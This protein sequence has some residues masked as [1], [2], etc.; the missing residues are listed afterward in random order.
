MAH[1]QL[2]ATSIPL[3]LTVDPW[4]GTL[5]ALAFGRTDDG[6]PRSQVL[7]LNGE[8]RIHL[9]V[10]APS[11]GPIIGFRVSAP[12]AVEVEAVDTETLWAGPRFD[13]PALGLRDATIGE[14]LIA[15]QARFAPD[16]ATA[17]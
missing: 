11:R 9:L 13:V 8:Q 17:D 7:V 5:T 16:E 10:D 14:I 3:H 1:S 4:W 12:H 6:L 2:A 15:A